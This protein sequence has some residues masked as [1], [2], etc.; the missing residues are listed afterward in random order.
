ML[1]PRAVALRNCPRGKPSTP[2]GGGSGGV[3]DAAKMSQMLTT[4]MIELITRPRMRM[5]FTPKIT[6]VTSIAT[7][8]AR[9]VKKEMP[10]EL[11]RASTPKRSLSES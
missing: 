9:A 8:A 4:S 10:S 3:L 11:A 6:T 5:S 7:T 1:R 2:A